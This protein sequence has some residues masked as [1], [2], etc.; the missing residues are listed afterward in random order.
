MLSRIGAAALRWSAASPFTNAYGVART[1]LALGTAGTL[2]LTPT[3]SIYRPSRGLMDAPYCIDLARVTPYCLVPRDRLW[4]AQVISVVILLVVASGWRP[5]LTGIPHWW[6]SYGF[7][8]TATLPDGGDQVTQV[9]TLLLIPVTLC[10]P[11]RWHWDEAP[12]DRPHASLVALSALALVR[13]QVAVI[14]FHSSIAKLAVPEWADGTAFWYWATDPSFGPPMW[15][16]PLVLA[17]V[18]EPLGVAL[19][20]WGP[21]VLEFGLALALVLNPRYRL[22]LLGAGISF[23]AAIAVLMGLL[24]FALAMSAA[25]VLYLWPLH[26]PVPFGAVVARARRAVPRPLALRRYPG[27]TAMR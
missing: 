3:E 23:H 18:R 25:L 7:A 20:T 2:G 24:S 19:F 22:W 4:I 8:V 17:I 14:Y 13:L 10:D 15:L 1:L 12:N 6:V 11:R 16:R 9:L 26:R 27:V 21:I 5:R